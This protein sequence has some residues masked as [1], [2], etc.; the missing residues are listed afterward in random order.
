MDT[1]DAGRNMAKP[2][3]LDAITEAFAVPGDLGIID[4]VHPDTGLG[5]YS[6]E[7]LAQVQARY[8][9]AVL[10]NLAAW[11]TAKAQ[12]Q[13]SPIT[14][15]EVT[16]A[17]YWYALEC[18]PPAYMAGGA[19]LVGECHDHEADTGRARFQAFKTTQA[20]T[21]F[22]EASRPMTLLELKREL[23]GKSAQIAA[24]LDR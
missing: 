10:V 12:A 17:R 24:E 23:A 8:P 15:H 16:R 21:R 13:R 2:S 9:G 7:T 18:L 14:W 4:A 11:K 20:D 6:G 3:I 22:W 1:H 19:F 5:L